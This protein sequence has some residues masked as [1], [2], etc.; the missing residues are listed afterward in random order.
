MYYQYFG[1]TENP[2]SISPDPRYLY[3]SE[4][5]KE[6]LAHLLYGT[7]QWGGFI[8]LTGE[9]GTGKTMLTRALLEQ[10]P[11]EV[12]MALLFNPRQTPTEFVRSICD[13][14]HIT[15]DVANKYSLKD[16]VDSLNRHLLENHS[17]GRR[18]A[19][20]IDEAQNLD[21]EVLEQ[22]RLLTNLE[23]TKTK[24][25]M[26][27]LVG[28]P[29]LR[30]LLAR[31]E[32]RQLAQR[33]TGRYHLLP[34]AFNHTQEYIRHRLKIAGCMEP[35]FTRAA[36]EVI[37]KATQG[38]PRLI[39]V[40]CDRA[41][42]GAYTQEKDK[43]DPVIARHAVKEI[44]GELEPEDN[45]VLKR[46]WIIAAIAAA[47]SVI[48]SGL[49]FYWFV[50]Q[51]SPQV[52][53][54]APAP[55]I[56]TPATSTPV[57]VSPE[58]PQ[59]LTQPTPGEDAA[60]VR[61]VVINVDSLLK[62]ATQSIEAFLGDTALASDTY[63]AFRMLFNLWHEDY[64]SLHGNGGCERA[65][66]VDLNCLYTKGTWN[67]LRELN[68]PAIIELLDKNGD[69]HHLAV[70]KLN[71]TQ[72]TFLLPQGEQQFL[73]ADLEPYW[74]GDVLIL[75]RR[76]PFDDEVIKPGAQ[77]N[78]ADWLGRTLDQIEGLQEAQ[79]SYSV[80]DDRL[81]QRVKTFQRQHRLL[82]DGVVGPQTLVRLQTAR[83]DLDAPTLTNAVAVAPAMSGR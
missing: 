10:I 13:E 22:I 44:A 74:Y 63:S 61:S 40:V 52:V 25:L 14:L 55:V 46:S 82:P 42:L 53:A 59:V 43:V 47:A 49:V 54:Q 83:N 57:T 73:T 27:I 1:L 65:L 7:Q 2:F 9:V 31:K 62:P 36:V 66:E 28:Q 11:P 72:V 77:G 64:T 51:P 41:L 12:D 21:V 8:Q 38:V 16:L 56:A 50:R 17:K 60:D 6:A 70:N 29:E 39:N 69:R 26:M 58:A 80:F 24:L 78:A 68:R 34:L 67:N 45:T 23:T 30:L 5:H 76:P 71:A 4:Q 33:I 15:Y 48:V 3:L 35:V 37:Q 75:W 32:L 19:V 79:R 18:T 20:M 81:L